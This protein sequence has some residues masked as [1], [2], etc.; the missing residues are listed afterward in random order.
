MT[1]LHPH[2]SAT[3][4]DEDR[5]PKIV[6]RR[7]AAIVGILLVIG[8]TVIFFRGLGSLR[9]QLDES[10]QTIRITSNRPDPRIITVHP[11]EEVRFINEQEGIPHI[12]TSDTLET[13]S[14]LLYTSHI[15]PGSDLSIVISHNATIGAHTYVSLTSPDLSGQIIVEKKPQSVQQPTSPIK[16]E[17]FQTDP[18]QEPSNTSAIPKNPYKIGD[19]IPSKLTAQVQP[20]FS[21]KSA[22][23]STAARPFT[24]PSTG[25][26][27]WF[28]WLFFIIGIYFATRK[29]M[30][31]VS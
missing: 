14:G 18:T 30:N 5:H 21:P 7:P 19:G 2:W 27:V 25:T 29:A 31:Q 1:V 11:G 4:H 28:V 13:D 17:D 9:A 3:D 6:S 24:Q 15:L 8:F 10:A 22:P 12:F 26:H 16:I 23:L 20:D